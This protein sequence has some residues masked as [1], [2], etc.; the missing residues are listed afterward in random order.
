MPKWQ[1]AMR[2]E[3]KG[4]I[5]KAEEI[6]ERAAGVEVED[7]EDDSE[8][9]A[10]DHAG[11][12]SPPERFKQEENPQDEN[13]MSEMQGVVS[14]ESAVK[15]EPESAP[16]LAIIEYGPDVKMAVSD[17]ELRVSV[18]AQ[19]QVD[20]SVADHQP[21]ERPMIFIEAA[22][23]A[24]LPEEDSASANHTTRQSP[25]VDDHE[26]SREAPKARMGS[27]VMSDEDEEYED[28]A[29]SSPARSVGSDCSSD[30]A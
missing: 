4:V 24:N 18:A 17:E 13:Q 7:D 26:S 1:R 8:A 5:N 15:N 29:I 14:G 21:Q 25:E 12:P 23:P 27:S 20:A 16:P 19:D 9:G 11:T 2:K 10:L 28:S 30:E 22:P 6:F 3:V